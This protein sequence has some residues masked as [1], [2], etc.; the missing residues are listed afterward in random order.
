MKTKLFKWPLLM[1]IGLVAFTTGCGSQSSSFSLAQVKL[2]ASKLEIGVGD[3]AKLSVSYTKGFDAELRWFTSDANVA[4]A[5]GNYV[6]GV[7]EGTATITASYGGGY[8][9]CVVTVGEGGGSS[10]TPTIVL[11]KA[12]LSLTVG[13]SAM[14][15][16]SRA[17]PEDTTFTFEVSDTNIINVTM[18]ESKPEFTVSALN[19]GTSAITVR[20]SNNLS[21]VCSV[22]VSDEATP[23]DENIAVD[24]NSN[25]RKG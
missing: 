7:G 12:S 24:K 18:N 5:D 23:G 3:V 1:S 17:Y 4:Y 19:N 8:A 10:T 25:Y 2:S 14:F 9:D 16:V 15:N 13:Q 20:G 11:S 6:F 21:R 22:T